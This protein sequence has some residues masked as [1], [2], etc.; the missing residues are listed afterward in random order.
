M[1]WSVRA[2]PIVVL[3]IWCLLERQEEDGWTK[4]LG[5][6][7]KCGRGVGGNYQCLAAEFLFGVLTIEGSVKLYLR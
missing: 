6:L 5:E 2:V 3:V 7:R 4:D 1:I